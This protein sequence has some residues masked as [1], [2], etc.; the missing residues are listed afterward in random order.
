MPYSLGAAPLLAVQVE[1][2]VSDPTLLMRVV[3][4]SEMVKEWEEASLTRCYFGTGCVCPL[5]A[6]ARSAQGRS[7]VAC[8]DGEVL[9]SERMSVGGAGS[10][11]SGHRREM[12]EA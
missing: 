9:R 10:V 11:S 5:A 6:S 3:R 1:P 8:G 12:C 2:V 4:W 7:G